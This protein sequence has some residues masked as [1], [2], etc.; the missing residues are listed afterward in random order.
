MRRFLL[1]LGLGLCFLGLVLLSASWATASAAVEASTSQIR[2]VA[3]D[4]ECG[5]GFEPCYADIQSAVDGAQTGDEIR[6][7]AGAY[8]GVQARVIANY[9][10]A[11]LSMGLSN[12]NPTTQVVAITKSVALV[13]GYA[14]GDWETADPVARPTVIDAEGGGRGVLIVGDGQITPTLEGLTITGGDA[15]D[16]RPQ[17]ASF[18]LSNGSG[19]GIFVSF[20]RPTIANCVITSNVGH[21]GSGGYGGG[22]LAYETSSGLISGNT[23][24]SNTASTDS[25]SGQ[26]GGLYVH[27]TGIP[28]QNNHVLS[29]TALAAGGGGIA[30]GAGGGLYLYEYNGTVAGNT[31]QGNTASARGAGGGGAVY[32]LSG[33]ATLRDNL[34]QYNVAQTSPIGARGGSG[35]GVLALAGWKLEAN[36]ILSNTASLHNEG[37][38]GGVCLAGSSTDL[39]GNT[40]Q[41]NV[42]SNEAAGYGGGIYS[43]AWV[44]GSSL[45]V[46]S[47][48]VT[49]NWASVSGTGAGGGFFYDGGGTGNAPI[50]LRYNVLEG[51]YAPGA[52]GRGGGFY[53]Y[54]AEDA[55]L[56]AN[57]ISDN[58]SA[59]GGGLYIK[60][61]DPVTL[62]NNVVAGNSGSGLWAEGGTAGSP[63]VAALGHNSW[64]DNGQAAVRADVNTSLTLFNSIV[65]SHTD[66]LVAAGGGI[67][68]ASHTLFHG[69]D[70]STNGAVSSEYETDADPLF[71]HAAAGDYDLQ[72]GSPAIDAGLD[73]AWVRQDRD[74]RARPYGPGW[75][76]GAFEYREEPSCWVYL[77]FLSR[78]D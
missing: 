12:T 4:G 46:E 19:G 34:I 2:Y 20:A 63:V 22:L 53:A 62:T 57:T 36:R 11:S 5:T 70:A 24:A 59:E 69:N 71:V 60:F 23:I 28:I 65:V 74:G 18:W 50:T 31:F 43:S 6:I 76:L 8:T 64:V 41:G 26:G 35:G 45:L 14:T 15:T 52:G 37:S 49:G 68:T 47:N 7:A 67:I 44:D 61:S 21:R 54:S 55:L 72:E 10:R 32:I 42:A 17:G 27:L 3:P 16:Q 39:V 58:T 38:G 33:A 29:N 66:G 56:D 73:L 51:N 25:M 78:V 75:D 9:G 77:P 48:Q 1:S 40:I 13:G 30:S